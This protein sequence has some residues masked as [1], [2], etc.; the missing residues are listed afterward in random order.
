MENPPPV[1]PGAEEAGKRP[2]LD[3]LGWALTALVGLGVTAAAVRSG[4]RLGTPAAPFLGSYR[5]QLGP[6]SLLAP[7]VAVV[8]LVAAA[9]GWPE[10]VRWPGLQVAADL[11]ALAWALAL[12]LVDGAAGLTRGLAAHDEYLSDLGAVGNHP[13]AF[14][15]TFTDRAATYSAATRG[16][17]PAAVLL[18]WALHRA[19]VTDR[20]A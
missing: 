2:W 16:H 18:L 17:P 13:L 6:A 4:A 9:R 19:G 5:W 7:A 12:A 10:R 20:L 3:T 15:T 14:L 11:T 1:T 8:V